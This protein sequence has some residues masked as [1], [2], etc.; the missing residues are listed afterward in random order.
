MSPPH[1]PMSIYSAFCRLFLVIVL[2]RS[3]ISLLLGLF[4]SHFVVF[5]ATKPLYFINSHLSSDITHC[6]LWSVLGSV[7]SCVPLILFVVKCHSRSLFVIHKQSQ[8]FRSLPPYSLLSLLILK[9]WSFK[10]TQQVHW[11]APLCFL[12]LGSL[13]P[14]VPFFQASPSLCR[15]G[16]LLWATVVG[17]V[18]F[19]WGHCCLHVPSWLFGLVVPSGWWSPGVAIL[20]FTASVLLAKGG[21][22]LH[23]R[24]LLSVSTFL[25]F[26]AVVSLRISGVLVSPTLP[27]VGLGF[28]RWTLSLH[29]S[30]LLTFVVGRGGPGVLGFHRSCSSQF[31]SGSISLVNPFVPEGNFVTCFCL[32]F[33]IYY[34]L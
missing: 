21:V 10:S 33:C 7:T 32:L 12:C 15:V 1:L 17:S 2:V 5:A 23:F 19:Q 25:V 4:C 6:R 11:V 16:Q 34:F 22:L 8:S 26:A 27:S 14:S 3:V 13:V 31:P 9:L 20:T 28:F 29:L 30:P 24:S 18:L